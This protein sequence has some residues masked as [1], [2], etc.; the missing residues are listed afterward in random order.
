MLSER[1]RRRSVGTRDNFGAIPYRGKTRGK[2]YRIGMLQI[3][4]MPGEGPVYSTRA[5]S[6]TL[7]HFIAYIGDTPVSKKGVHVHFGVHVTTCTSPFSIK[8]ILTACIARYKG[9]L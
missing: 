8:G 4:Y 2:H 6:P 5:H 7:D 9:I 3:Q 1:D